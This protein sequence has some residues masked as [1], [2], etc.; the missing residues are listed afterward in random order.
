[1]RARYD[2]RGVSPL[3][4]TVLLIS[5]A[6]ALGSVVLNWGRNLDIA[7][8]GDICTGISM[9]IRNVGDSQICYSG[10][11]EN[12]YI[13]FI[14]DNDGSKNIDGL[15]IWVTGEKGTKLLDFNDFSIK[16]GELRDIKDN[17]I[18]Y[19]L[20]AYGAIKQIQFFPKVKTD[21]SIELCARNSIKASNIKAC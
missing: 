6:V 16:K 13:N 7:K 2:K 8:P 14:I 11:G 1:M 3:I 10:Q 4:A 12:A 9:K 21:D 15:G 20:S 19:D 17:S 18:K 5:F